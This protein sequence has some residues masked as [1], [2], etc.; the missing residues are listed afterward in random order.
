MGA[1]DSY[2]KAL[3]ASL[4]PKVQAERKEEVARKWDKLKW[5]AKAGN[6]ER[7]H[8][9]TYSKEEEYTEEANRVLLYEW[10]IQ[11]VNIDGKKFSVG[12]ALVGSMVPGL[13]VLGFAAGF[14]GG[15]KK[16][17]VTYTRA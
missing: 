17:I 7:I 11:D 5:Y 16:I 2:K 10:S 6:G 14:I 13:G 15:K 3:K 12:K 9:S 4:D 1:W 8:V